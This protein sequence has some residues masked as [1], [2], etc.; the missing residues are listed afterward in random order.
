[1]HT[2]EGC[3]DTLP[4]CFFQTAVNQ[5]IPVEEFGDHM[6]VKYVNTIQQDLLVMLS[7]E[8]P[9]TT[10]TLQSPFLIME[11]TKHLLIIPSSF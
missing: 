2:Q 6:T 7:M 9:L 11:H 4:A 3:L 8:D 1:M 10:A 5:T